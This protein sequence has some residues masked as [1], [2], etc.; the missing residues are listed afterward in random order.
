M[1]AFLS[2]AN[3]SRIPREVIRPRYDRRGIDIGIVHFGPGA[4]H[5]VHQA[6]F[7]DKVLRDDPRWGICAVSLRSTDVRDALV[8]QDG[9]SSLPSTV[10]NISEVVAKARSIVALA[11]Q[12][13]V[14]LERFLQIPVLQE[15]VGSGKFVLRRGRFV[16]A[17]TSGD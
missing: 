14:K 2:Q 6:W 8:P 13:I 11:H 1:A 3:L 7:V 15:L 9:F 4:F 16:R 5:R 17:G 12:A 10:M